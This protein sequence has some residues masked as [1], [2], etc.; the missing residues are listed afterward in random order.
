[1]SPGTEEWKRKEN[2]HF[3]QESLLPFDMPIEKTP[4]TCQESAFTMH[5]LKIE[6]LSH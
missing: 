3:L 2:Q 4:V 1:M 6:V 5:L